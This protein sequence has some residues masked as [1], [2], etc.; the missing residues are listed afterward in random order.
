LRKT[1]IFIFFMSGVVL[2][3]FGPGKAVV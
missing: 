2:C 3:S 1:V